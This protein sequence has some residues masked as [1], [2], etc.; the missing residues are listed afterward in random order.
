MSEF[1]KSYSI[2][3]NFVK[4][5]IH[6][7]LLYIDRLRDEIQQLQSDRAYY[8]KKYEDL[9]KSSGQKYI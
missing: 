8:K 1:Y 7:L 6:D 5:N 9:L 4:K 3:R 2:G